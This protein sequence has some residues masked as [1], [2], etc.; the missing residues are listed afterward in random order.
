MWASRS[1]A[2]SKTLACKGFW[3]FYRYSHEQLRT[4]YKYLQ[5]QL[6][7]LAS[8]YCDVVIDIHEDIIEEVEMQ[9]QFEIQANLPSSLL[10]V[11]S[12]SS[13]V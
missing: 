7:I 12:N 1:I 8:L 3:V 2:Q 6:P 10:S 5:I 11:D 4:H 9:V 13:K